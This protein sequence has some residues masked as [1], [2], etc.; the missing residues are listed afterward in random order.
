MA[1]M[2]F[3]ADNSNISGTSVEQLSC[4]AAGAFPTFTNNFYSLETNTYGKHTDLLGYPRFENYDIQY[5]T[6]TPF[7]ASNGKG[8]LSIYNPNGGGTKSFTSRDGAVPKFICFALQGG[9]GGGGSAGGNPGNRKAG[10]G[11][12]GGAGGFIAGVVKL[13]FTKYD[14]RIYVGNGGTKGYGSSADITDLTAPYYEYDGG[15]GGPTKIVAVDKSTGN[16]I[17]VAVACGGSGGNHQ[18]KN[19]TDLVQIDGGSCYYDENHVFNVSRYDGGKG[20]AVY[21]NGNATGCT[22]VTAT[23][24]ANSSYR[25]LGAAANITLYKT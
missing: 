22:S 3:Y 11:A 24:T 20:G 25:T 7:T 5:L 6:M 1:S 21:N 8:G 2:P 14:Y 10:D 4:I 12:G 17:D 23:A 18:Q 19:K 16:T 9:G 15:T 13:D